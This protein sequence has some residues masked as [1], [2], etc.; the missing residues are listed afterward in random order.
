ML[1]A[2]VAALL[3]SWLGRNQVMVLYF[4][5]MCPFVRLSVRSPYPALYTIYESVDDI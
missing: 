4:V 1:A 2:C 3:G 5:C